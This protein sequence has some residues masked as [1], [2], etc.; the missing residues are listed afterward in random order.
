MVLKPVGMLL[1]GRQLRDFVSMRL[2]FRAG[3]PNP[4]GFGYASPWS[5][6][7]IHAPASR[8]ALKMERVALYL[9]DKH[10]IRDGIK[11]AQFAEKHGLRRS[12]RLSRGLQEMR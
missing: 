5:C 9:Q 8:R 2:W 1:S 12:G 4:A 10:P 11:Y 3:H 7:R 6:R